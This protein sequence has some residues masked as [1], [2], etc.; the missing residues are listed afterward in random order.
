M[1]FKWE[2]LFFGVILDREIFTYLKNKKHSILQPTVESSTFLSF[3]CKKNKKHS[4]LQPTVESSTFL[5]FH[6]NNTPCYS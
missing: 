3:H 4:I 5:S 2:Q 6:C 1:L